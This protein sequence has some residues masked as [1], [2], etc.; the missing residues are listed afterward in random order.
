MYDVSMSQTIICPT[1]TA[2]DNHDYREQME[3][4]Q[5]FAKRIH[6][7]LMDGEF[8]PTKSPDLEHVWWPENVIADIHLMYKRPAE[9]LSWLIKLKPSLVVIHAEAECDFPHPLLLKKNDNKQQNFLIEIKSAR[10]AEVK[11]TITQGRI[12]CSTE[13]KYLLCVVP[14]GHEEITPELIK[15]NAQFVT[16]ITDL[17][18]DRV[19][20]V[21]SITELQIEAT[22]GAESNGEFVRTAIEGTQIRYAIQQK[23]WLKNNIHTLSFNEFVINLNN[24]PRIA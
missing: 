1:V 3:K 17:L 24:N 5:S 16:N 2:Y 19:K 15:N 6:I 7:D 4:L 9:Q 14:I 11:M 10:T 18:K 21:N 12:A 8:A 22:Q 13:E 23:A 20:K